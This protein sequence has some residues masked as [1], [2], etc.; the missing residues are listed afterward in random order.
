[1]S[2]VAGAAVN[3]RACCSEEPQAWFTLDAPHGHVW[4]SVLG[5]AT[6]I[7]KRCGSLHRLRKIRGRT[8]W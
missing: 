8:V 3:T 1:M 2:T 7:D 4:G 6:P 5:N